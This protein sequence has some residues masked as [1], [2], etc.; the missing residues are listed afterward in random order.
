MGIYQKFVRH[1]L[2][3]LDCYRQN[4]A[5]ILRY[6]REYE[7]SQYSS[8]EE[9]KS[10]GLVRLKR[11]LDRAYQNIPYYRQ[12]FETAGVVP[13]DIRSEEDLLAFP[14]LEK[15]QI[16]THRDDLLDPKWSKDDLVL[17]RTG[18]STGTPIEYYRS[19]DRS[20]SRAAATWRHNRFVGWDIGDKAAS[21]WGAVRDAPLPGLKQKLRNLL[22]DRHILFNTAGKPYGISCL[23]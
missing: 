20:H 3:P 15:R 11:I 17:D 2:H 16:Q 21:L 1:C 12:S 8:T 18:G 7:R 13:S 22:M 5:A 19:R 23:V 4:A 14:I 6:S 10:E 9:L